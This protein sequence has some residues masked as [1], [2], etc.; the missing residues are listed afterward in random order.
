MTPGPWPL[1]TPGAGLVAF[2]WTTLFVT[3]CRIRDLGDRYK[4]KIKEKQVF[5]I[6]HI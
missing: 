4:L 1:W 5:A 6:L 3:A 2:I